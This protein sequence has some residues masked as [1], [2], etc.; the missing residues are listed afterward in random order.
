MLQ[1]PAIPEVKFSEELDDGVIQNMDELIQ[2]QLKQRE[3]DIAN[4]S[5][6]PPVGVGPPTLA[7]LGVGTGSRKIS[8]GEELQNGHIESILVAPTAP[9]S[10]PPKKVTFEGNVENPS[11][12]G[13]RELDIIFTRFQEME[14]RI[15]E[16]EAIIGSRR[17]EGASG[18][19][20]EEKTTE[21]KTA[22]GASG[23][24]EKTTEEKNSA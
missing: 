7:Q 21:E 17:I 11:N 18:A 14:A 24:E 4:Y 3:L 1:K 10:V 8:I 23:A 16:L 19:E 5:P 12:I 9:P 20:A 2:R 6:L 13:I 22:E 15:R